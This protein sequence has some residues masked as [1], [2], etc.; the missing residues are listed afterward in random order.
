MTPD[1]P[2]VALSELSR[3]ERSVQH[4]L[5]TGDEQGL[6][7]LGHGEISLVLGCPAHDPVVAAKR[8]PPFDRRSTAVRYG[9][10]IEEYIRA[11]TER[12]IAVA[13]TRFVVVEAHGGRWA[14]Y[15]VQP[16]L[17]QADLGPAVLGRS[18][19]DD[20]PTLRADDLVERIVS[21]IDAVVDTDVGLDAQLS[22]WADTTD[23]LV[24]FDVTTP[25]LNDDRGRPRLDLA[26]LA[27][28]L[29]APLRPAI[30]R[31]IAPGI[32]AKYHRP[33]EVMVDLAANLLKERL[34]RWVDPTIARA[35]AALAAR[36]PHGE[37]DRP[38]IT[39]A[40]VDRYYRNDAL[41]WEALL[42]LRTADRWWQQ[43]VRRRPYGSLLPHPTQR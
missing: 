41:T 21:T 1:A 19:T 9:E 27:S 43:R 25:L 15:V 39:R 36:G 22:N 42:R 7:V 23:E 20:G 37:V 11:L 3:L 40:E 31:V 17:D 24:Y 29:P 30:R 38:A 26:V 8:L 32:T 4:A 33:R 34:E 18:D 10:L 14:G 6:S 16:L 12:G 35:N 28:P 2:H 13:P 5:T